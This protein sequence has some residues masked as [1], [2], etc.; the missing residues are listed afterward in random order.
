MKLALD[1]NRYSDFMRGDS[2]TIAMVASATSLHISVIVLGE[3][4]AGFRNG[5]R[6]SQNEATL[7]RFLA[8]PDVTVLRVDEQTTIIYAALDAELRRRGLPIPTNDIWIAA[9]TLQ[10]GLTLYTRDP[11]FGHLPQVPTV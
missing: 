11:H 4:R 5:T 10:H 6:E 9:L 3:L 1:T 8:R 2:D 7:Q